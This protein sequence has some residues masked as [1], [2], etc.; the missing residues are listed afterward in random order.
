MREGNVFAELLADQI[1]ALEVAMKEVRN[2]R[3]EGY[4]MVMSASWIRIADVIKRMVVDAQAA[5]LNG[6]VLFGLC[7]S[8]SSIPIRAAFLAAEQGGEDVGPLRL[9]VMREVMEVTAAAVG[10]EV[11]KVPNDDG[12]ID[13]HVEVFDVGP[14]TKH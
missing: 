12:T 4:Q 2:G 13:H 8:L 6:D 3:I 14:V 10:L 7:V 9:K 11:Q 5:G 1:T